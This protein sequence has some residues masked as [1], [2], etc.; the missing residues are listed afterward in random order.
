MP[1]FAQLEELEGRAWQILLATSYDAA[2]VKETRV[3]DALGDVARVVWRALPAGI[4]VINV[5]LWFDRKLVGPDVNTRNKP[6]TVV[7]CL[8]THRQLCLIPCELIPC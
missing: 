4:P 5:H 3:L 1:F 7:A 2:Q 6:L 8:T